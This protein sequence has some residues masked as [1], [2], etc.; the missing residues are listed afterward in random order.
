MQN[1]EASWKSAQSVGSGKVGRKT[2]S[3]FKI[4]FP[5]SSVW[6]GALVGP[7]MISGAFATVYFAP[8]GIWGVVLLPFLSMGLA[9]L[10]IG[11]G[12]EVARRYQV[13]NYSSY[14]KQLYG[15]CSKFLTPIMEVY[16]I[17]A[18]IVGG[19]A[20]VAMGSTFLNQL[21]GAP[22]IAGAIV[23]ALISIALVLWGAKLVRA[24]SAI[25]SVIMIGG[26]LVLTV[27]AVSNHPQG[28]QTVLQNRQPFEG[29]HL[30]AGVSGAFA[31]GFSN[32]CNALTLCAVEQEVVHKKHSLAIGITSFL[33]NSLA[34]IVST[35]LVLPYCP[36]VLLEQVPTLSV[37]QNFLAVKA[38]WLPTVYMITMFLALLSSGA[39]QLHAVAARV[40]GLYPQKG[41][42]KNRA[43][44]NLVTGILYFGCCIAISQ[45]GLRTIIS[46]GYSLLGYLAIP[47][48]AIPI[49]IIMPIR[50]KRE[51]EQ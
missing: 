25:M 17:I 24:S 35:L 3:C 30:L 44:R 19:S 13:Y 8:Y 18:M 49:C 4:A 40:E 45:L 42:L 2:S 39:P 43:W 31:L 10:I 11:M 1:A 9:A 16:M 34:F 27:F 28:L 32:A 41:M 50:A 29:F 37:I 14:A 20:V 6:F 15:K 21:I 5:V 48:I 33:M 26:M 38:P 46:Q 12:A 7:S 47:L 51:G 36:E 23:M 22:M